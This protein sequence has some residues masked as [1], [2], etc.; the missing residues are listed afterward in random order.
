[1]VPPPGYDEVVD[2]D[3][4]ARPNGRHARLTFSSLEEPSN[5]IVLNGGTVVTASV[6]VNNDADEDDDIG[7]MTSGGK[8]DVECWL[9]A[10]T[11]S[12]S[13]GDDVKL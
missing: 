13:S 10:T 3:G 12:N 6:T 9:L 2:N 7:A 11:Y 1:M 5:V 4:G 8:G